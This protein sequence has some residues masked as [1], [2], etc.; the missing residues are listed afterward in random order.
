MQPKDGLRLSY[1]DA[2][3][4]RLLLDRNTKGLG[5]VRL[6]AGWRIND[7]AKATTALRFGASIP[8]GDAAKLLGSGGTTISVGFA[9][10]VG[11]VMGAERLNGFYR[12]HVMHVGQPDILENRYRPYVGQ[13][14]A[15]LG[16]D[17]THH[18]ELRAQSTLRT[19]VYDSDI[20]IL[21]ESAIT[22]TVG[23]NIRL[24]DRYH[25]GIAVAE[26]VK[27]ESGPD[28]SLQLAIHY[29]PGE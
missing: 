5:D 7:S 21:G 23:G 6:L 19:A 13:L 24:T 29:R 9:R 17:L 4:S 27:V 22:L 28:V 26:D 1:E 15:G 18:V 16:Y 12:L 14:S 25:L 3:G 8:T 11:K 2:L 10:D 20:E